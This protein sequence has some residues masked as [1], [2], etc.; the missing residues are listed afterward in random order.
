MPREEKE[1]RDVSGEKKPIRIDV[2]KPRILKVQAT[3]RGRVVAEYLLKIS[4]KGRLTL[5]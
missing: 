5:V 3:Q 4:R 1:T 2:S